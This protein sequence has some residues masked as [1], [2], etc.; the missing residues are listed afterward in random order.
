[1]S[2]ENWQE[3][4]TRIVAGEVRRYRHERQMSAQR[5]A[6]RCAMLGFPIPR[7]VLSNIENGRREAITL[8]ELLVLAAALEVPPLLLVIPV[9]RQGSIE[10][11]PHV[12]V[13]IWEAARWWRGERTGFQN[14]GDGPV[15]VNSGQED[16]NAID[17]MLQHED[18]VLRWI[19]AASAATDAEF[20]HSRTPEGPERD[21]WRRSAS[22]SHGTASRAEQN[23]AALRA[24]MRKR[25]LMPPLIQVAGL[26]HVDDVV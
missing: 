3:G 11:V 17:L 6:D 16:L 21:D 14:L 15:G 10:I 24:Q 26:E 23:L 5:L 25:G 4:L 1:M 13:L 19:V 22:V 20:V 12:N 7:P 18:L 8:P 2:Q 9:G